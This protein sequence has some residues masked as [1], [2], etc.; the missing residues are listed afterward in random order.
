VKKAKINFQYL[1]IYGIILTIIILVRSFSW[2]LLSETNHFRSAF[3]LTYDISFL[4]N[5]SQTICRYSFW[6]PFFCAIA[7]FTASLYP[8]HIYS[9]IIFSGLMMLVN[10][11]ISV[12]IDMII[13][14]QHSFVKDIQ[15]NGL[16]FYNAIKGTADFNLIHVAFAFSLVVFL[17]ML[18]K[19]R[20]F[21]LQVILIIWSLLIAYNWIQP[22]VPCAIDVFLELIAGVLI[23]YYGFKLFQRSFL[24]YKLEHEN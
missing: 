6:L 12:I 4:D 20:Y 14:G 23:G 24:T 9:I 10:D 3:L 17:I 1:F 5:I 7:L 22:G 18:F 13:T 16:P 11:I 2:H 8:K 15:S 19:Q 21:L